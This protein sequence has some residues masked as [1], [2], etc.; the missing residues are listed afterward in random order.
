MEGHHHLAYALIRTA[1][2]GR[3]SLEYIPA[4]VAGVALIGLN[5]ANVGS[6]VS[7]ASEAGQY[8]TAMDIGRE[9][10]ANLD[11]AAL[12]VAPTAASAER[13]AGPPI[14]DVGVVLVAKD[15]QRS[16]AL[17]SQLLALPALFMPAPAGGVNQVTIEGTAA[18]E[19]RYPNAPPIL[20]A[21]VKDRAVVIGTAGATASAIRAAAEGKTIAQDAG[22]KPLLDRLTPSTSKAILVHA[23][24]AAETAAGLARGNEAEELKFFAS[25]LTNLRIALLTDEKPT[26]FTL[27]AEAT[28]L[29]NMPEA[30]LRFAEARRAV[31]QRQMPQAQPAAP[32]ASAEELPAVEA[33]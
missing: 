6:S 27:R 10:F 4:G 14:P 30:F 9:L 28:G 8:V 29:P 22:F 1:P 13:H 23:G 3:S 26:Q 25:V 16:E 32:Q 33:H 17:W 19:Y 24:R 2:C 18:T 5:P 12:F 21:R 11:E 31:M 7:P 20:L 15:V